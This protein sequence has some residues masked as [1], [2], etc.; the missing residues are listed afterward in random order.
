V[1]DK[2]VAE[3]G[4]CNVPTPSQM[5]KM[6]GGQV[7]KMVID[8]WNGGGPWS[9]IIQ[10]SYAPD[11]TSLGRTG[12][13]TI[14]IDQLF[15]TQDRRLPAF[16]LAFNK[17]PTST[18]PGPIKDT[19]EIF[20][21]LFL[22]PNASI[23]SVAGKN[24][25]VVSGPNSGVYNYYKIAQGVRAR[26]FKTITMMVYVKTPTNPGAPGASIFGLYN[27]PDSNVLTEPRRGAPPQR[28]STAWGNRT[29]CFNMWA[30]PNS[31]VVDYK[32]T[33]DPRVF[34]SWGPQVYT[35]CPMG[36]WTHYAFVW[37]EDFGGYATYSNGKLAGHKAGVIAPA[38]QQMFE[39]M[40]I[41]C[42]NTED[43]AN[44]TGGIAWFRAFDYRLSETL[45]EMDMNDAW[46]SLN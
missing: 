31:I 37:D 8:L 45:I 13:I 22:S 40:R 14:P 46:D 28:V 30:G 19:N 34:P 32:D 1:N 9:F 24:C 23:G 39:Q 6:I 36:Q 27:L 11:D 25:L 29:Q 41:G 18:Q 35:P 20:H 42:D 33:S 21:N 16:E 2:V 38:P 7:Y 15:M 43:G 10:M 5:I 4:C 26:A 44:W 12:W 3:V 17:M